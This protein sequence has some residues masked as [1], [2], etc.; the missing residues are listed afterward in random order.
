MKSITTCESDLF[1]IGRNVQRGNTVVFPTDTIYGL[2]SSPFSEIGIRR[3]FELKKRQIEKKLP[4]LFSSISHAAAVVNLDERARLIAEKFWP[5]QITLILPVSDNRVP[6]ELLS[7]DGTL[8]VRVPDHKCCLKLIEACGNSLIGTSANTSG[9]EPCIDPD[10]PGLT[11]F[12]KGAD[13]F[14]RGEC[15]KVKLPSTILDLS[16]IDKAFVL[17]EGAVPSKTISNYLANTSSTDFS[18][19]AVSN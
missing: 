12:A 16:K 10:D 13:Y 9:T 1:D 4:I 6:R 7:E 8:A 2:G 3:C 14:I 5:G 17:R 11:D 18:L 19:N 15:G